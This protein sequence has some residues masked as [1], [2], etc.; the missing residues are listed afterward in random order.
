MCV[1]FLKHDVLQKEA[2]WVLGNVA[3]ETDRH[4]PGIVQAGAVVPLVGLLSCNDL[5]V[6]NVSAHSLANIISSHCSGRDQAL[7]H[8][9]ITPLLK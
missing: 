1:R 8:G 7:A 4:T 9:V 6:Q 3:A 5:S 2:A